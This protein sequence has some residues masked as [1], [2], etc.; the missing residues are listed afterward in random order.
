MDNET[1]DRSV[2]DHSGRSCLR[3]VRAVAACS[4]LA[5]LL[6]CGGI[7]GSAVG[8][9]VPV[10]LFSPIASTSTFLMSLDGQKL[11]EWPTDNAPGYS[12][13]LLPNGN[14]LRATSLPDRPFSA[15]QGSNGGRVEILDWSG[16]PTWRFDYATR[17]GQQHHDVFFM[18]NSGH[19]LM[20][21]WEARSAAEAIAAGRDPATLPSQG[22]LWVDKIVEVNPAN[23]QIVWEWRTWDH[24]VPPGASPADHP[25]LVDPNYVSPGTDLV[26]W[27]HANAVFYNA[28]LDQVMLSVRNFSEFWVIDHSTTT[29]QAAG[30]SGGKLGKGGDIVY[31]WGNPQAYGRPDLPRQLYGQHNAQWIPSGLPGAGHILV[32]DNGDAIARPYSRVVELESPA[33]ADGSYPYDPAT[34]Y[35]PSAPVWQYVASPPESVF[36]P[37]ISGAQR[38]PSGNTFV[39]VGT[40]GRFFEVTP[41]GQTVWS[42]LVMDTAGATGYLVFR[43]TRYEPGY[44]GLANQTLVP[45]GLLRLTPPAGARATITNY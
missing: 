18:P 42:Y 44:E 11:H 35:G 23:N 5:S 33:R 37:I 1:G 22:E 12:V 13:Y 26:D 8:S 6:A 27:T 4:L 43:A 14:L 40:A 30:H 38:L 10:I 17:E 19:V 15:L 34:G 45:E 24:L 41:D 36:A 20:V 3:A 32:F 29:E 25:G 7:G 39:T 31:R 16:K 28:A 21:A 2:L 9:T